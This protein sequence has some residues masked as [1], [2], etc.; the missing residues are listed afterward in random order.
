MQNL[1]QYLFPLLIIGL[2]ALSWVFQKL[3]ENYQAKKAK[4][5]ERRRQEEALRQ[6]VQIATRNQMP[7]ET[8]DPREQRRRELAARR[9]EQLR[10]L[11]ERQEQRAGT[12]VAQ[13][14]APT[15]QRPA[16]MPRPPGQTSPGG[17]TPIPP[18]PGMPTARPPVRRP[19]PARPA[20]QSPQQQRSAR[21]VRPPAA[22]P[23]ITTLPDPQIDTYQAELAARSQ[24][25]TAS[26]I[27]QSDLPPSTHGRT[28]RA[29]DLLGGVGN[30]ELRRA[31]IL[32]EIF[33]KPSSMRSPQ[34]DP[35][36]GR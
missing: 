33:G 13:P 18:R 10:Q 1:F 24:S 19:Q 36:A 11:R 14:Q 3:N 35:W 27:G 26:E 5:A 7:Q 20:Q 29:A 22:R 17:I 2:P 8:E 30:R 25:V 28:G 16:G 23:Q 12:L 4:E 6:T 9:A 15:L 21:P 31:V 32:S 34:E